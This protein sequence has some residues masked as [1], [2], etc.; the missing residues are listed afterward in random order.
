MRVGP[1]GLAFDSEGEVLSEARRSAVCTHD[2]PDG[3]K[4]AQSV[5]LAVFMARHGA[6]KEDIRRELSD[7]FGYEL[8]RTID[9]IRPGYFKDLTCEGSVPQSLIAF[10]DSSSVEDAIRKA[11]SMGGDADTMACIAGGIAEAY[12]GPLPDRL[13]DETLAR[14]TPD[15]RNVVTQFHA[16]FPIARHERRDEGRSGLQHC[17]DLIQ[18]IRGWIKAN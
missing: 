7:R 18:R 15:I 6:T 10:L 11:I 3:I 16:R 1:I 2:H 4:G 5:A 13:R 8:H 17:S 9:E 14:L 12:F